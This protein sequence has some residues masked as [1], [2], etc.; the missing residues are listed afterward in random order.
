MKRKISIYWLIPVIIISGIFGYFTTQYKFFTF[1]YEIDMVAV[2]SLLITSTLAIY[3]ASS[4]QQGIESKKFEKDLVYKI[5]SPL[6][7]KTKTIDKYLSINSLK[8]TET[9]KTFKDISSLISELKEI[10]EVCLFMEQNKATQIRNLF[11]EIKR[12]TTG[13]QLANNIFI[14][15]DEDKG[16]SLSKIKEFKKELIKIMIEINRK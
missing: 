1:K 15:T 4:I 7:Q 8:F 3:I 14:L 12:S 10:N 16:T 11:L 5:I 2:I 6:I 9:V 13:S